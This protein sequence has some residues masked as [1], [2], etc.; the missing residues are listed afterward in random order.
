MKKEI[1][2]NVKFMNDIAEY[3][4]NISTILKHEEHV[5]WGEGYNVY[6]I[7]EKQNS[8]S[9]EKY[10]LL[11]IGFIPMEK[12][13]GVRM[14]DLGNPYEDDGELNVVNVFIPKESTKQ[15]LIRTSENIRLSKQFKDEIIKEKGLDKS[16]IYIINK[17]NGKYDGMMETKEVIFPKVVNLQDIYN[18]LSKIEKMLEKSLLKEMEKDR[19]ECGSS[20][21]SE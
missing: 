6:D 2:Y 8:I 16:I 14:V 18:K 12:H 19:E 7:V 10:K 11:I 9:M 21:D 20:F 15:T 5:M 1:I 13:I 17:Q 3:Y 4:R